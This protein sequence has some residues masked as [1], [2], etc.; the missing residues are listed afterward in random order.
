MVARGEVPHGGTARA[1]WRY[2]SRKEN[3]WTGKMDPSITDESVANEK[4]GL[5]FDDLPRVA[6]LALRSWSL[7]W[8]SWA[9][10]ER[11]ALAHGPRARCLLVCGCCSSSWLPG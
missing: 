5:E 1:L 11:A 8:E 2:M 6:E 4:D 3:P 9:T 10:N 7:V